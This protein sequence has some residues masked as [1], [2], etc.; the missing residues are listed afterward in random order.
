[1][2]FP[3]NAAH[4]PCG[5]EASA[6]GHS[7]HIELR[8]CEEVVCQR[9]AETISV[10]GD[11]HA[12]AFVEKPRK[13]ARACSRDLGQ[14]LERPVSGRVGGDGVLNAMNGRMWLRPSSQG[15]S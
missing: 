6:L 5:S 9:D 14:R 15:E 2:Q 12:G 11:V 13:V 8:L 10:V 3:P 4:L 7:L 1:M